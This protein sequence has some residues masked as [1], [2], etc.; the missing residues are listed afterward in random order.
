MN[1]TIVTPDESKTIAEALCELIIVNKVRIETLN[2]T[3]GTPRHVV[4]C[5]KLA[6]RLQDVNEELAL[7]V[8]T[9]FGGYA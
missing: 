2:M 4:L 5:M 9:K 1:D 3:R 7:L 8:R 6:T